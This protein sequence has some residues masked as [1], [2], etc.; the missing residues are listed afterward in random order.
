MKD[1]RKTL[2][3]SSKTAKKATSTSSTSS[4]EKSSCGKTSEHKHKKTA[5]ITM[6]DGK[7]RKRYAH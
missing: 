2:L 5:Y 7:P 1:Y 3:S 4:S 6:V